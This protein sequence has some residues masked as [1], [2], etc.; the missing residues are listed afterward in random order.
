MY[1]YVWFSRAN[2]GRMYKNDDIY[3]VR[4]YKNLILIHQLINY[5]RFLDMDYVNNLN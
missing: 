1:T 5:N 2:S 3:V 4:L